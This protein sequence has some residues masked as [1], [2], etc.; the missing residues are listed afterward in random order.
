MFSYGFVPLWFQVVVCFVALIFLILPAALP[1][2]VWKLDDMCFRE[3]QSLDLR[4][5]VWLFVEQKSNTVYCDVVHRKDKANILK[6]I[7]VFLVGISFFIGRWMLCVCVH[8]VVS[9]LDNIYFCMWDHQLCE[10]TSETVRRQKAQVPQQLLVWKTHLRLE[11][12]AREYPFQAWGTEDKWWLKWYAKYRYDRIFQCKF[13][14]CTYGSIVK[15]FWELLQ[16]PPK[17]FI[18]VFVY[19]HVLQRSM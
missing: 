1:Y 7:L 15:Y 19:I 17:R 9:W 14:Y 4:E 11:Y 10:H 16:T 18:V 3:R 12:S 2:V 6:K 5:R 13:C 8:Q